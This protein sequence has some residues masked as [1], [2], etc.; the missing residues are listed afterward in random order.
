MGMVTL[1]LV[2]TALLMPI[3]VLMVA[4]G[5]LDGDRGSD[6]DGDDETLC[7]LSQP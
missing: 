6:S 3:V 5:C 1:I 7:P 4:D 2:L